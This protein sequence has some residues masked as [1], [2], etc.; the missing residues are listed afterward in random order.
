[1]RADNTTTRKERFGEFL[2]RAVKGLPFNSQ[3]VIDCYRLLENKKS[4]GYG[5]EVF[6]DKG[7]IT[8][9]QDNQKRHSLRV[10]VFMGRK[11]LS[12]CNVRI[13]IN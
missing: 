1:M 10:S 7:F 6:C 13:T 4:S 11:C 3:L 2:K 12:F 5:V 8:L 9:S